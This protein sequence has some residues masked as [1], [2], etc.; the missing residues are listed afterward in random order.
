NYVVGV[1]QAVAEVGVPDTEDAFPSSL[2]FFRDLFIP[3]LHNHTMDCVLSIGSSLVT[4][5]SVSGGT[6]SKGQIFQIEGVS[7]YP[8]DIYRIFDIPRAGTRTLDRAFERW[9]PAPALYNPAA[10]KV[11]DPCIASPWSAPGFP[12]T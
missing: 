8:D 1:N 6:Q 7:G 10:L 11:Y 5:N 2:D 12:D 9:S 4:V 3:Y